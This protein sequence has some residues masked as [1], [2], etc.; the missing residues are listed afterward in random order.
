LRHALRLELLTLLLAPVLPG[1][2][3]W[4]RLERRARALHALAFLRLARQFAPVLAALVVAA[5]AALRRHG[6]VRHSGASLLALRR[7]L[8][9]LDALVVVVA[10][11]LGGRSGQGGAQGQQRA[12]QGRSEDAQGGHAVHFV[13]RGASD[14]RPACLVGGRAHESPLRFPRTGVRC[15]CGVQIA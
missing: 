14:S 9:A 7:T 3:P 15:R 13:S 11:L 8:L 10:V 5:A 6:P 1:R 12:Q 2:A 4:R